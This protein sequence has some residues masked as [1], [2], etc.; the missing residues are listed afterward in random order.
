MEDLKK[1]VAIVVRRKQRQYPLLE[2]KSVAENASKENLFFRL[3]KKGQV[4]SDGEAAH[5]LYSATEQDDR[6]RMLKSRLK[7]KLLNHLYFLDFTEKHQQL[8]FQLEQECIQYIHQ[9]KMLIFTEE[10][11]IAR[12]LLHKAVVL[13]GRGEFTVLRKSSLEH[14]LELYSAN[15]QPHLYQ[16]T[17]MELRRVRKLEEL[18]EE[19]RVLYLYHWMM[20]VKSVNSRKKNLGKTKKAID[21]LEAIWRETRSYNTFE[22]FY[23]LRLLYSKLMGDFESIT[24]WLKEIGK[25]FYDKQKLNSVRINHREI[26]FEL[27]HAYWRTG[28]FKKCLDLAN[29]QIKLFDAEVEGWYQVVNYAF[30]SS[31]SL[32][33][34]GESERLIERVTQDRGFSRLQ[35]EESDKWKLYEAY[36]QFASQ[37]SFVSRRL[38]LQEIQT[39]LPPDEK[40]REG[41]QA[42]LLIYQFL[43]YARKG[44]LPALEKRRDILR[45]LMANHFKENFS[46]RT[47]TFYKL[48][49]IVVE[50]N[51][52]YRKILGRS[53]YLVNKL[54]EIKIVSD[55]YTEMEIV[56]YEQ[57]WDKLLQIIQE[58]QAASA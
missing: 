44:D 12:N 14:L 54:G 19:G 47:R 28:E 22:Q 26:T 4:N 29:A 3:I 50:Q 39:S 6:Y 7:Q 25:G 27:L 23:R 38:R 21:R 57:L 51:L 2:L 43:F 48:L 9:A 34:F 55:A 36:L 41:Y 53:R 16:K 15:F 32:G 8:A 49:N 18:E 24:P 58:S 17:L 13:G 33:E 35:T 10:R 56:P 52:D 31:L 46:Y 37:G 42:A 40:N 45:E 5:L 30:L 20:V 11:K 1:L